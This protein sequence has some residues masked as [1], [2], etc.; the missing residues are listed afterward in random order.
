MTSSV[1]AAASALIALAAALTFIRR[2]PNSAMSWSAVACVVPSVLLSILLFRLSPAPATWPWALRASFIGSA[3]GAFG[4]LLWLGR[5]FGVVPAA[6]WVVSAGPYRIIRHPA[7]L[8]EMGMM[9]S[10]AVAACVTTTQAGQLLLCLGAL[11]GTFTGVV[12]RIRV[13]ERTLATL[14]TWRAYTTS[15]KYRLIPGLW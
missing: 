11:A 2:P 3:A 7:Y 9:T 8:G 4:S 15:T 13:E 12:W 10:C 5:S 14:P 6:R 1:S